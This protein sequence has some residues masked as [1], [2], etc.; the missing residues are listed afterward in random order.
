MYMSASL[1]YS[2]YSGVEDFVIPYDLMETGR[3]MNKDG[4]TLT[5]WMRL[6]NVWNSQKVR[7]QAGILFGADIDGFM[8]ISDDIDESGSVK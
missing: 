8:Q 4:V 5:Q 7:N 2:D 3:F 1:Q 6:R